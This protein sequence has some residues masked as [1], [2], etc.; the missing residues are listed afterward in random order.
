MAKKKKKKAKPVIKQVETGP[1]LSE[2]PVID[3]EQVTAPAEV[4]VPKEVPELPSV[5]DGMKPVIPHGN[6]PKSVDEFPTIPRPE[7]ESDPEPA[8][9][10]NPITCSGCKAVVDSATVKPCLTC[11]KSLK[12]CPA[13]AKAGTC[14]RCGQKLDPDED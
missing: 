4:I 7:V 9:P 6:L 14:H 3:G 10:D 8:E 2:T 11:P 12:Y 1:E 13:C 5:G